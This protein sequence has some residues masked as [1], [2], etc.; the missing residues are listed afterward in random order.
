V[1]VGE[2]AHWTDEASLELIRFLGR[3]IGNTHTLMIVTYRDDVLDP[4]HPLRRVLGDL[5]NEPAVSRIWLPPLSVDAIRILAEG[6]GIEPVSLHER[7]AGNPFYATEILASGDTSIPASIR[8]AVLARASRI[9]M[10][11]RAVLD[12]AAVIGVLVDPDLLAALM[13]A[14]IADAV[15]E[16][17]AEGIFRPFG[18]RLEFRHGLAREVLLQAMSL[19]RRRDLHRRVLQI[20]EENPALAADHAHLAHHAEEAHDATAVLRYAPAAARDAQAFGAHRQAAAQY[21]RTLRFAQ[22]LPDQEQ[23]ELLEARSYECYLTGHLDDAIHDQTQAVALWRSLGDARKTGDNTR[24]LSRFCWFA[25][26]NREA[27]IH[28]R[29]ALD[30]L[31]PLPPGPELAM[32]CSNLSQIRMLSY[33]VPEAIHWGNRAIELA[34]SLDNQAILAHALTNVGTA[35]LVS[36]DSA[37][38][39]LIERSIQ[40]GI[41]HG[42]DDDVARAYANLS[43]SS[44]DHCELDEAERTIAEGI[45]FTAERDLVAMELYLRAARARAALA[46]GQWQ[47]AAQ[48][49]RMILDLPSATTLTRIPTLTVLGRIA[50][51]QGDDPAPNFDEALALAEPTGQLMRLGPLR[52]ARAEAAWLAGDP[53]LAVAEAAAA[54]PQALHS[55]ERWLAGELALWLHR[56]GHPGNDTSALAEPFALEI[57]GNGHQAAAIWRDLGCPLEE[58]RALA[59]TGQEASLREALDIVDRLGARPDIARIVNHL[60]RTGVTRIPRG[61]RPETRANPANL[62]AR[63]LE[64]LELLIQGHSNREIA[65]SLYLS[66]RTVGHHVSAILGKLRIASRT[67]AHAR[68]TELDLFPHRSLPAPN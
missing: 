61:P 8:D 42:L 52:A 14:P 28:A 22:H 47:E 45:A 54:Y 29:A 10:E 48:E 62:T 30:L 13:G 60:R 55:G 20:M 31:E 18:D 43:W 41:A 4:Y 53:E 38:R 27:E 3:R 23:A 51:R 65:S 16:C 50:A 25:G 39:A 6:S 66:P 26:Q 32:A 59:S 5:V 15:D 49:A 11:S 24:W 7:T 2:D 46:R 35:M 36:S 37:G 57:A 19:P 58:A 64:V 21:A 63:E 56:C 33:D 9:G 12:A 68:A 40:I 67:E 34:T 44:L 17:L 1:L